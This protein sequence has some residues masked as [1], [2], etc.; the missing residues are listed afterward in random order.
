MKNKK[1][2]IF[3]VVVCVYCFVSTLIVK[4][5]NAGAYPNGQTYQNSANSGSSSSFGSSGW[6]VSSITS[7]GLPSGSVT[8][9]IQKVLVW[10]LSI[11]G[12][13]GVIG[14]VISGLMY[15]LSTGN[16]SMI[17]KAKSGMMYSIL[18]VIVGLA[19]VVIIQAINVILGGSS[20]NI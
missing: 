1:I 5:E 20:T 9:I 3:I 15:L 18:G 11:L 2:L 10:L 19:G 6:S 7:Y 16:D 13:V 8:S 17:T 14:F 4:A 12:L